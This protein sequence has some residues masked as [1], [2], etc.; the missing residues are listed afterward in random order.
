MHQHLRIRTG[1]L[2]I[3]AAILGSSLIVG[4]TQPGHAQG[5]APGHVLVCIQPGEDIQKLAQD[6]HTTV[7][8]QV[9]GMDLYSL[10]LPGGT[11]EAPF[12]TTL[13]ADV[14]VEYAE[15]D[16]LI[17]SPEVFGEPFHFAFDLSIKPTV[18]ANS[19]V[20]SQV[21]LTKVDAF[22]QTNAS[23]LL[24]T[25]SGSVVAVL[26]TGAALNHPALIGHFVPGYNAIHPGLPPKD[27]PDGAA[28]NEVGHG[29][30][31]AGVIARLAPQ[32]SIMPVRVLNGDGA[33]T[34]LNVVKGIQYAIAHGAQVINMSFS[35]S[36]NSSALDDALDSAENAGVVLVAS[37]G[38]ENVQIPGTIAAGQG[39]LAVGAVESDNTKSPYSNY[40]SFIDVVAPGSRI[41]STFWDGGYATWSGTSFAAPFVAAEAAMMLSNQP[42]LTSNVVITV[43][44]K[45][46]HSVDRNNPAYKGLLGRG[47]IDIEAAVKTNIN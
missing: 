16:L 43:I 2:L 25:G 34:I 45:T 39:I 32:A 23:G 10:A 8:E 4:G 3:L 15:P 24:A 22:A 30:M 1:R 26:D 27:E 47:M 28:N 17:T 38:N 7:A 9:P 13:S 37:A 46:A 14:R 44:R 36:V 19:I 40:G 41:R 21:N 31:V 20:Y 29:T 5:I 42:W 12:A 18:Y 11:A 6:Y 35:S 33:G